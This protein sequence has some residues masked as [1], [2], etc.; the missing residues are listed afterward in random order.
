MLRKCVDFMNY[1]DEDSLKNR[2]F[3]TEREY[4]AEKMPKFREFALC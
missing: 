2:I 1:S 3:S 4:F